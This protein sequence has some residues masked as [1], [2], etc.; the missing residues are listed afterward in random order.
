[1]PRVTFIEFNG[2][3]H[4]VDATNGEKLARLFQLAAKQ[5]IPVVGINDS[6][7]LPVHGYGMVCLLL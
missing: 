3:E 5:R 2:T 6:A 4:T 1:M 7:A